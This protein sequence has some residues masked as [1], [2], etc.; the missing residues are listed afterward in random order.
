MGRNPWQG[1]WSQMVY[2]VPSSNLVH[3]RNI[4]GKFSQAHYVPWKPL[5]FVSFELSNGFCLEI[6]DEKLLTKNDIFTKL[7]TK[8]PTTNQ[9]T[10]RLST[11]SVLMVLFPRGGRGIVMGK[12]IR[13]KDILKIINVL[14]WT[15]KWGEI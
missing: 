12:L 15:V 3:S 4:L 11:S 2:K 1:A 5:H 6:L 9:P 8:N 13:L 10:L 7:K 14:H